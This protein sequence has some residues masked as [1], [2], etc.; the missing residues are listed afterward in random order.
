MT[1]SISPSNKTRSK[2]LPGGR[3]RC[4]V[5]LPKSE[6]D[7]LDQQAEKTDSSRSSLIAQIY[8][9]GKTSNTK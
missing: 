7:C 8:Y 1:T 4:T 9:Q 5:Y 3:V 2:K 6:V